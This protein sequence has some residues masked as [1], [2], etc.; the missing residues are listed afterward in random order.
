MQVPY[1]AYPSAQTLLSVFL[2]VL[3]AAHDVHAYTWGVFA[4][5]A[6]LQIQ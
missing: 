2:V 3:N 1:A 5:L 6:Q 4:D